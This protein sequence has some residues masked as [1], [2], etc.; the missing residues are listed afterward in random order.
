MS[1]DS[2]ASFSVVILAAAGA[3]H[4]VLDAVAELAGP[5]REACLIQPRSQGPADQGIATRVKVVS[6]PLGRDAVARNLAVATAAGDVVVCQAS[7]RPPADL[8]IRLGRCLADREVAAVFVASDCVAFRR[9]ELESIGGFDESRWEGDDLIDACR[10]LEAAGRRV[11]WLAAAPP[12]RCHAAA[13]AKPCL[14]APGLVRRLRQPFRPLVVGPKPSRPVVHAPG[15]EPPDRPPAPA[16]AC[17]SDSDAPVPWAPMRRALRHAWAD[18][19]PHGTRCALTGY[20]DHW[21]VGDAAIWWG[22]RRLLAELGVAVDYACDPW[23]YEPAVLS[24]AVPSGPILILGGGN[25]GDAYRHEQSL[26]ERLLRDFPRRRI[27]QLPQSIWFAAPQ[28]VESLADLLFHAGDATLLLRDTASL[29]FARHTFRCDSALCP[30]S[31]LALDLPEGWDP[32]EVPML[33]LWRTDTEAR[34]RTA[35]MGDGVVV[36]DWT[37]PGPEVGLMS[38]AARGFHEW[39]GPPPAEIGSCPRRRRLAWRHLPW[40]WDQ[41]AED[42]VLR[43]CRILARGRVVLTDRLHAHL[44]CMLMRKPHVVCDSTNGKVFAYRDTW[45]IDDPLVRYA[46]TRAEAVR[47]GRDLL[48]TAAAHDGGGDDP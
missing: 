21:N 23:S 43:G 45:R 40:L 33:A 1:D 18:L 38:T 30:D 34:E 3:M 6:E 10:R 19:L 27:I 20:P 22:T 16:H 31:A 14:M 8:F 37:I 11:V 13:P 7:V 5:P 15:T 36:A 29:A 28:R 24:A 44:L 2:P 39:V 25:L 46:S 12:A 48:A 42:R 17:R 35:E 4:E 32:P 47:L 41:L 9:V 26:R